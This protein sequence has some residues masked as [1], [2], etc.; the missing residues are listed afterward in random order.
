M[1]HGYDVDHK[2]FGPQFG[3]N[4]HTFYFDAFLPSKYEF[5]VS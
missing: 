2:L 1:V 5:H 4:S 3:N